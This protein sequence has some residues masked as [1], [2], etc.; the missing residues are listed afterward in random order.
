MDI[1]ALRALIPHLFIQAAPYSIPS[2][3]LTATSMTYGQMSADREIIAIQTSGIHIHK[4]VTPILVIG[5]IF[6]L[7]TLALS[8][9][10]LPRSCYKIILQERAISNIL[11]GRLATFEKKIDL[12]PYQIYIGEAWK[13]MLIKI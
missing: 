4:I 8:S 3:L 9:E 1:I 13:T 10:I 7:I 11:A 12:Y 5:V 2:A 6:S